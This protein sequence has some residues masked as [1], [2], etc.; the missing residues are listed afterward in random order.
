MVKTGEL[1]QPLVNL[2]RDELLASG[3]VQCDET[4]YQVLKAAEF[5]DQ[6]VTIF[7]NIAVFNSTTRGSMHILYL[8]SDRGQL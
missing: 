4:R 3:F 1:V 6:V 8:W 5:K 7:T 2:L